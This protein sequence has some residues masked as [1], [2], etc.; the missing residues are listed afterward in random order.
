VLVLP[1]K[2]LARLG[3]KESPV[4]FLK[5]PFPLLLKLQ[6]VIK[7]TIAFL[8]HSSPR[9]RMTPIFFAIQEGHVEITRFLFR[10]TKSFGC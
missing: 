6:L 2:Y 7:L 9:T 4:V 3:S 5:F 8:L 1:W 10:G